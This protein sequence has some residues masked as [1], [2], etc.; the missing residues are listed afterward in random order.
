MRTGRS[1][2][3]SDRLEGRELKLHVLIRD[4]A[5]GGATGIRRNLGGCTDDHGDVVGTDI[6]PNGDGVATP[7]A[8]SRCCCW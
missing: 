2:E 1:G 7:K 8:P 6:L 3:T 5:C 4:A